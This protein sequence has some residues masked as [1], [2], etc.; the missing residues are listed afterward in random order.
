MRRTIFTLGLL[1]PIA[2]CGGG[3]GMFGGGDRGRQ[4]S[5]ATMT[6]PTV[7]P[8]A[9]QPGQT[10]QQARTA[11]AR[12]PGGAQALS[13]TT[14]MSTTA[15]AQLSAAEQAFMIEAAQHGMAEVELGRLAE[16]RGS[17][18]QVRDFGRMMVQQHTQANQELMAIAQRMG[19]TPPTSLT[20]AAQAVQMRLQQAQGQEFDRQYL[21][22]QASDHLT[23]RAMFQFAANN[24]R[25]PDL[26]NFAQRTLPVVER[27][28][29]QLRTIA[30]TAM[31]TGS[32]R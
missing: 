16:S 15:M 2:A 28:I 14:G 24:A 31:R 5:G 6:A 17:S 26:R 7:P 3:D 29:E 12:E 27:H 21:E 11:I 13:G 18:A 22:H 19:V 20:P 9:G 8:Q 23:Q 1:L 10:S 30:P 32:I 4:T 25:N